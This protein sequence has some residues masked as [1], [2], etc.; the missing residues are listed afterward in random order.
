MTT[1]NTNNLATRNNPVA[2]VNASI[3]IA[4]SVP[5]HIHA[6]TADLEMDILRHDINNG[7]K[8]MPATATD[9][10]TD[11]LEREREARDMCTYYE[12]E[13][14]RVRG[15]LSDIYDKTTAVNDDGTSVLTEAGRTTLRKRGQALT[16]TLIALEDERATWANKLARAKAD[17]DVY[18]RPLGD[19]CDLVQEAALAI[20]EL[21]AK[22]RDLKS[23]FDKTTVNRHVYSQTGDVYTV[24]RTTT[25]TQEAFRAVREH[26]SAHTGGVA[27]SHKYCYLSELVCDEA[28]GLEETVYYRLPLFADIGGYT[29]D[30]NGAQVAYTAGE[31]DVAH[32]DACIADMHLTPLQADVLECLRSGR[33]VKAC[34]RRLSV[35]VNTVKSARRELKR[36]A[37]KY[38]ESHELNVG[39]LRVHMGEDAGDLLERNYAD[40]DD[41]GKREYVDAYKRNVTVTVAGHTV[42]FTSVN[43]VCKRMRHDTPNVPT[44]TAYT[45]NADRREYT[46]ADGVVQTCTLTAAELQAYTSP[47][48]HVTPV[49]EAP[50]M[51]R[52]NGVYVMA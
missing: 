9:A 49:R 12:R 50:K 47:K 13:L 18:L 42:T 44:N 45:W 1:R 11:A 41:A 3:R 24:K 43:D 16:R 19:G 21:H 37:T 15:Q 31:D 46:Q 32:V 36:K 7:K 10:V 28:E 39:G 33:G 22:K 8:S 38:Y 34:A 20:C 4:C 29:V 23:K 51:R 52:I 25:G 27:A 17:V 35:S 26:I 48:A 40:A 6:S 14:E 5:R 2:H 30:A